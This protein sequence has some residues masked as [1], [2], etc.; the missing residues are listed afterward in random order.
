MKRIVLCLLLLASAA[1]ATGQVQNPVNWTFAAKKISANTY[2]I[3]MSAA[4]QPGWR[5]YSQSSP[6]GGP[7]AT[8][9]VLS[10]NP[11]LMKIGKV[12]ETGKLQK[13]YDPNFKINVRYYNDRVQFVQTVRVNGNAGTNA[14]GTIE[15]MVCNEHQ[16]LPP[17]DKSFDVAVR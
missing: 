15:Y 1:V 13:A 17:V 11:L 16:C 14:R 4:V 8:R 12:K 7:V 5:I 3:I 6:S 10:P 2:D 9:I